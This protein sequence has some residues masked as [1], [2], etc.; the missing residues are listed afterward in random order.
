VS[1][2]GGVHNFDSHGTRQQ[3]A[4]LHRAV[5]GKPL[6]AGP[7]LVQTSRPAAIKI[8][9]QPELSPLANHRRGAVR[10]LQP[11]DELRARSRA[12]S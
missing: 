4:A 5:A 7:E 10:V 6:D 11:N 8:A 3:P 1:D 2:S 9:S 12:S